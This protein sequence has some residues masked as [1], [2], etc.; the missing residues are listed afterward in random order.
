MGPRWRYVIVSPVRNEGRHIEKTI[1][2]VRSQTVTPLRWVVVDDGSTDATAE[3]A[4]R[5]AESVPWMELLRLP[6]RGYYDLMGGG[7]IKAFYRGFE[8]LA[9]LEYDFLSKLDGDISFGGN[10]YESLLRRFDENRRLGIAGGSCCSEEGGRLVPERSYRRHVRGAARVYR[11]SCW[12]AIGG[13]VA[14]LGW[15]AVDVYKARMLGW[16]TESFEDIRMVHHVKTWTKGG[17]LHGR[18]R[19]GRMEYLMGTWPPFLAGK[20][21]ASAFRPPY[22]IGALCTAYGYLASL[23]KGEKRV[24]DPALMAYIRKEQR[25]RVSR[26]LFPWR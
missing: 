10:Y 17:L 2:S 15:D 3:I 5:H 9:G 20:L 16:D 18:R 26:A 4:A 24:V 1:L 6:D 19:S 25:E 12:D 7:E 22:G 14:D 8:R 11:R 13:V 21:A 23:A